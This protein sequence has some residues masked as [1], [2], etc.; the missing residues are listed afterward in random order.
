MRAAVYHG[1]GDVRVESVPDPVDPAPGWVLLSVRRAALCGTDV[2]E[3]AHGPH[4]TSGVPLVIG[5]E[6][7]G[8]VVGVGAGVSTLRSGDRVVSGAGVSCGTCPWCRDG[9]TNLC[10]T[11]RTLGQSLDGGLAEYVLAPASSAHRVPAALG[12]DAAAMAQPCAVAVHAVRRAGVRAGDTVAVLGVGGIG[13]FVVAAAR[14][15]GAERVIAVDIHP[16]RLDHARAAGADDAIDASGRDL[17]DALLAATGP[18]GA[19][20]VVEAT[21]RREAVAAAIRGTRRGGRVVL[22]GLPSEPPTVDVTSLVVREIDLL[23][24]A[25]HVADTDLPAALRLLAAGD[26]AGALVARV[27]G[28]EEVVSGGLAPLRDGRVHGKVI[29]DPR[30][31]GDA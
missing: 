22:L 17:A 10:R 21:G 12:D 4:V 16:R 7:V 25:A 24:S 2:A 28:L 26:L 19:H 6:F 18:D 23:T 13:A 8:D 3:W 15:D 20:V 29:V 27:I 31:G 14:A 9:R 30:P 5:H 11:Y 1:R